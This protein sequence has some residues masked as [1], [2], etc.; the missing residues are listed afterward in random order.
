M[1][2]ASGAIVSAKVASRST[3]VDRDL[4]V[5]AAGGED[6]LVQVAV[7]VSVAER[8]GASGAAPPTVG[9]IPIIIMCAPTVRARSSARLR[10]PPDRLLEL[11]EHV[12][13]EHAA[14][15]R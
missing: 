5:L 8:L 14:A 2:A 3:P 6:L 15:A 4:E 12:A 13:L 10:L 1:Q 11:G 7:A 9:R